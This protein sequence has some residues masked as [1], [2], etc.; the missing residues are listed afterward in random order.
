MLAGMKALRQYLKK[1]RISQSEFA[2][3]VGVKQP[4]VWYWLHGTKTPSSENLVRIADATGLTID[5]LLGRKAA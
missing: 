1:N 3:Q 4:S 2:R 5:E